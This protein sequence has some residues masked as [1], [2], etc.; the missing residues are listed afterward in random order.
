MLRALA[1]KVPVIVSDF[2]GMTEIVRDGVNGFVFRPG[3]SNH[4]KDILIQIGKTPSLLNEIKKNIS[5]SKRI[6][7]EAFEY[8]VLYKEIYSKFHSDVIQHSNCNLIGMAESKVSNLKIVPVLH[9]YFMEKYSE[10]FVFEIHDNDSMY[11]FLKQHPEIKDPV[12]EYYSSGESMIQALDDILSDQ[13]II[14]RG[15]SSFLD[16]ASGYGRFTRFLPYMFTSGAITVSD[17]DKEAVDFCKERIKV[18]GFYSSEDPADLD[19]QTKFDIIWVA[20]LFSHLSLKL[21]EA[22]IEKLYGMLND[23]GLLIFSTHGC[24]CFNMLDGITKQNILHLDHGFYFIK[25]SEINTLSNNV[26]GTTYVTEEYVTKY[27]EKNKLGQIIGYYP[28]KLWNFQDIYVI[29]KYN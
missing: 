23:N 22:W 9:T 4:L 29:K 2:P 27:V 20:S 10:K 26:Y 25:Q 24:H 11:Q 18:N 13:K 17:I 19:I 3:D 21:W 15:D 16:F 7:E 1:H 6:E 8:E 12:K 5:Y 14:V 28:H